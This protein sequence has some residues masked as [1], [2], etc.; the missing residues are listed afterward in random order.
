[1]SL[2]WEDEGVKYSEK[3]FQDVSFGS[4]GTTTVTVPAEVTEAANKLGE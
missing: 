2:E 3:M 1:V 4:F